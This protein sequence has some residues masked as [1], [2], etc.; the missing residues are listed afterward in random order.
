MTRFANTLGLFTT[1]LSHLS[2]QDGS[3]ALLPRVDGPPAPARQYAN[4]ATQSAF[5]VGLAGRSLL[6]SWLNPR[7]G[8]CTDAGYSPCSSKYPFPP[9]F[10]ADHLQM[11]THAVQPAIPAALSAAAMQDN[12][13]VVLT[14][15]PIQVKPAAPSDHVLRDGIAALLELATRLVDNAALLEIIVH[16]GTYACSLQGRRNA[17]QIHTARP[18]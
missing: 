9:H 3:F 16:P 10:S 1:F 11:S 13:A 5:Q 4:N 17:V 12:H 14:T 6:D 2:L 8:G 18:M 7:D 15:A